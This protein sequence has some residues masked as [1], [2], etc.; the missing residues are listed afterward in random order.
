MCTA[1]SLDYLLNNPVRQDADPARRKT[2]H[3]GEF[4]KNPFKSNLYYR[5]VR[6]QDISARVPNIFRGQAVWLI[7]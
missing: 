1:W 2:F 5:F 3:L 6:P 4:K 7:S